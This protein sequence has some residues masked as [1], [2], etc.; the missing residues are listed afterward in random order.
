MVTCGR[1]EKPHAMFNCAAFGIGGAEVKSP[2]ARERHRRCAHGARFQR[3]IEIAIREALAPKG[4]SRST[5]GNEFGVR[6]R[7]AVGDRSVAGQRNNAPALTITQ[8]TG[9]SPRAPAARASSMAMD[10]N[11]GDGIPGHGRACPGHPLF[12]AAP[13]IKTWAPGTRL[14]PEPA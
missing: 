2:N 6:G 12:Y 14:V 1:S 4:G 5:N 10:M 9:T 3:N 13:C 7:V 11:V 8:P